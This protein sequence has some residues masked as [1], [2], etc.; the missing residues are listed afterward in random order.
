MSWTNPAEDTF[1]HDELKKSADHL[2]SVA[3]SEDPSVL[4]QIRY[5][6]Y[7]IADT[8]VA[9]LYGKNVPALRALRR[10]VDP[11]RVMDLTGGFRVPF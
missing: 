8:P 2:L 9:E 4:P 5:P 3:A 6:N 1:W 10:R 11:D 7:A